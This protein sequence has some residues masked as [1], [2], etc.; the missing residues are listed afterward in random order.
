MTRSAIAPPP[1]RT[2]PAS[3][4]A[5]SSRPASVFPSAE[6]GVVSWLGGPDALRQLAADHV[7]ALGAR[8]VDAAP[9]DPGP[10]VALGSVAVLARRSARRGATRPAGTV[11]ALAPDGD[12]GEEHW[13]ACLEG[14]VRAVVRLPADSARLLDLLAASVRRTSRGL[15]IGVVGGCGGAGASSLAARLAGAAARSGSSAVLVDADP[16]GG[17][18]DVLVEA[19]GMPG[20]RW[21]DVGGLGGDDGGAL[22]DGLPVVDGVHVLVA[23]EAALPTPEQAVAAVAA[24]APLDGTVVV[25]VGTGTVEAVLPLLDHVVLVVPATDHAVRAAARRLHGWGLR[26]GRVHLLVRRTGP[27]S[28][29]DVAER[30][31]LRTSGAF[32]D[33]AAGV[34]PLLDVRR[35]GA[36]AACR[37][38]LDRL[39]AD[40]G[41]GR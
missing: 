15:V 23:R 17:G 35:R 20:A 36:D 30:L 24:L 7:G 14:G 31:G 41:E 2:S 9:H 22:R 25:D 29:G 19:A 39:A 5:A 32:R 11:I 34:V 16:L 27:L 26:R 4:P 6:P 1:S 40:A 8:L 38:L 33:A 28:P 13:R 18:L 37:R 21:E 10:G 3:W 12:I